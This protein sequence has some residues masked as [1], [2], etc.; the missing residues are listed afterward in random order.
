[1]AGGW[2]PAGRTAPPPAGAVTVPA[3]QVVAAAD[4]FASL[5]PA[6]RVSVNDQPLF[7]SRSAVLVMVKV[8]VEV[9]PTWA[10]TGLN[11]LSSC[12]VTSSTLMSSNAWSVPLPLACWLVIWRPSDVPVN[13]AGASPV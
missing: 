4:G 5:R 11:D 3:A 2:R 6:G 13:S 8:S 1:R 9:P 7:A 10:V 12:G